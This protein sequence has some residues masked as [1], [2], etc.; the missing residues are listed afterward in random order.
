MNAPLWP[1]EGIVMKENFPPERLDG[2]FRLLSIASRLA[3]FVTLAS[4]S[5]LLEVMGWR[6]LLLLTTLL[7][8]GGAVVAWCVLPAQ[9][10]LDS[11]VAATTAG[12][13]GTGTG[14]GADIA[15]SAGAGGALDDNCRKGN[16]HASF[17]HHVSVLT[18]AHVLNLEVLLLELLVDNTIILLK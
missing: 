16:G 9:R 15:S 4:F 13:A 2:L 7:G 5:T 14:T 3:G 18:D 10:S 11:A 8:A 6:D 12:V 17:S 1:G